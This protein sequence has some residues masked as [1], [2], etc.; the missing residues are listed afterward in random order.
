MCVGKVALT[1]VGEVG[2]HLLS[3]HPCRHTACVQPPQRLRQKRIADMPGEQRLRARSTNW[4]QRWQWK[5]TIA[6]LARSGHWKR[7][8]PARTIRR[9]RG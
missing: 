2:V 1:C 8:E 3:Q 4:L 7:F 9:G 5:T 6:P